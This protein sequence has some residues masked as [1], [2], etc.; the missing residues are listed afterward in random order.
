MTEDDL[1]ALK[2]Q[3]NIFGSGEES[4]PAGK[5]KQDKGNKNKGEKPAG[6]P[7]KD[8]ELER[9]NQIVEALSKKL[10]AVEEQ[11]GIAE[12]KD[13]IELHNAWNVIYPSL[14]ARWARSPGFLEKVTIIQ[15]ILQK[16]KED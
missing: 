7:K 1:E 8:K 4:I 13:M 6:T 3:L 10:A 5:G 11:L 12:N 16:E 9:L 15:N 14:K 2:K